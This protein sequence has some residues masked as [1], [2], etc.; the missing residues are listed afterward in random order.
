[1]ANACHKKLLPEVSNRSYHRKANDR[2]RKKNE[3][4]M[5]AIGKH[6]IE[7]MLYQEWNHPI[8]RPK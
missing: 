5:F 2:R 7:D 1:M 3:L 6:P 4:V 8:S